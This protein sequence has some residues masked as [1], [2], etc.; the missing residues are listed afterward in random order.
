MPLLC[1]ST[2]AQESRIITCAVAISFQGDASI[3]LVEEV[4]PELPR[5]LL[6][7]LEVNPDL[8]K[9]VCVIRIR[10]AGEFLT[11]GVGVPL[12]TMRK[13]EAAR[14]RAPI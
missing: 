6:R 1:P 13:P 9:E 12:R 4:P 2:R 8:R 5:A 7:G 11:Y 10:P 3:H 14:G